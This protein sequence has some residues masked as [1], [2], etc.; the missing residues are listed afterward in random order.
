[1]DRRWREFG[2]YKIRKLWPYHFLPCSV[3]SSALKMDAA[4]AFAVPLV[5]I[6]QTT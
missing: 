3:Y 4:T 2:R 5:T 6:Y 1:M